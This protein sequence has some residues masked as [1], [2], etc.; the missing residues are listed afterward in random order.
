MT[1]LNCM[2]N[3]KYRPPVLKQYQDLLLEIYPEKFIGDRHV[4]TVTFQITEDCCLN[5]SYCYQVHNSIQ[6]PMSFE[7]AKTFIDQLLSDNFERITT[8]NTV[9]IIWEFIGG[10]PFLQIDLIQK[11]TDYIYK[12]M[13]EKNHPWL[14]L[15]R[16]SISSNGILYFDPRVQHY[17]QQYFTLLSLNISIDGNKALHDSCR[18]DLNGN[19]SYDRAIA[20]VRHFKSTYNQMPAIKMTYAPA[21]IGF[22]YEATLSLI[23]EGYT[24]LQGNCIFEEGW[25]YEHAT[26][27]YY[28]LK[29]IADYLIDNNLYNKIYFAFFIEDT[30]FKPLDPEY[31]RN[32]CGGVDCT[33]LSINP[34]GEYYNCIR[35]MESSLQ[36]AQKPLKLGSVNGGYLQTEEER[37]NYNMTQGITRKSQ[38]TE[39]CFNC[40]IAGGCAWCSAYN[41]QVNGTPNKRVTSICPMHKARALGNV[42][43][44]NK[45][46]R[47]LDID[48]TFINYLPDDESLKIIDKNELSMLKSLERG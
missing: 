17:I 11:I 31:N 8:D 13:T 32:W 23:E 14:F 37:S 5:C 29:R 20:A 38:S 2:N 36:G 24:Q 1:A 28:Q 26:V 10:E 43:F 12:V 46:Y 9:G 15:S 40:P 48:K 39:E 35:Y 44:W 7:T 47:T 30:F 6:K 3:I 27:L 16:I 19:G 42:Y 34:K 45:L 22:M 21:N 41:Y 25:T 18:V 4:K 33:M